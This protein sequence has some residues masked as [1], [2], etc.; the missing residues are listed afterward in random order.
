M[1]TI[2]TDGDNFY[3]SHQTIVDAIE[4]K[5]AQHAAKTMSDHF[6]KKFPKY[7]YYDA[8]YSL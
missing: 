8:L 5:N 7:R 6:S 1:Q 2:E 4:S 3:S